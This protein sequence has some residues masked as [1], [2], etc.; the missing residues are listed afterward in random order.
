MSAAYFRDAFCVALFGSAAVMG[1]NRLPALLARWPLLRHSLGTNVPEGLDVLNPAMGSLA[2]S[3]IAAFLTVGLLGIAAGL[4]AYYV[5][6]A[7]MRAGLMIL[8]A[9]L[10]ATNVAT[11]GAFFRDAAFHLVA[12]AA[13]WYGVTHI[14]RFNVLGYFL[15]AAVIAL[16]PA[17]IELLE[18]PNPYLHANGYG[19][20]GIAAAIVAWPLVRWQSARGA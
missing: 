19:V 11:A 16:V 3:V 15:L 9:V 6:S 8:Y 1:L 17:A 7:W 18:Q 2:T 5:R 10:M 12:V 4:I 14:V 13:L 20:A